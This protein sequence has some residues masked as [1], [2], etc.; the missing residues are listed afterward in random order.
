[1]KYNDNSNWIVVSESG[2]EPVSLEELK[3]HL[4]MSFE[5]DGDLGD[6][7]EYL[8]GL[9]SACRE[10]IEGH[11]G[12]SIKGKTM[13]CTARN[14]C[15]G[16]EIPWGPVVSISSAVDF[17]GSNVS[18][19]TVG[20]KW[21]TILSPEIDYIKITY[22]TGYMKLG[23]NS[24][25]KA[26]KRAILEECAYRYSNRGIVDGIGSTTARS[27]CSPFKRKTWLM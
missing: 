7:D 15:G 3:A 13:E 19:T 25:P 8:I 6:D 9:I 23:F 5:G 17:Y 22:V 10:A 16:V 12:V 1:M 24:V 18:L 21:R 27:L 11:C 20:D 26:L 14:E 2:A 4:N